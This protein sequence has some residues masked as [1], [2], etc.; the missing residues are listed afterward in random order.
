[1]AGHHIDKHHGAA[2]SLDDVA[3]DDLL[4]LI[5]GAL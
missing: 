4:A 5:V 1:M 2:S 3:A